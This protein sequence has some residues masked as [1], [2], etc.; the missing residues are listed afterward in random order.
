MDGAPGSL[1]G[2]RARDSDFG[3]RSPS[4]M[5]TRKAKTTT[6]RRRLFCE[7]GGLHVEDGV[8]G[9]PVLAE[10]AGVADFAETVLRVDGGEAL[11]DGC[12]WVVG[13]KRGGD[14]EEGGGALEG[15]ADEVGFGAEE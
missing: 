8:G 3:S 12:A 9:E 14:A 4:G 1:N 7:V 11:I 6:D 15:E 2:C 10:V 13:G 5:T